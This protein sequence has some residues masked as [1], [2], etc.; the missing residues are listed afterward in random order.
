M[1]SISSILPIGVRAHHVFH[2]DQVAGLRDRIVRL[3]GDHQPEH[4]QFGGYVQLALGSVQEDLAQV[5]RAAFR[6]DGPQHISEVFG[7]VLRGR[8]Q[9][10][11]FHFDFDVAL[12]ALDFGLAA[13]A[14]EELGAAEV[15]LRRAAAVLVVDCLR[16][17]RGTVTR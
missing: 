3:G 10:I 4:L 14:R 5:G 13:S 12:L 8:L 9:V 7:A 6:R 1:A 11:E 16:G 2:H 15:D 17:P